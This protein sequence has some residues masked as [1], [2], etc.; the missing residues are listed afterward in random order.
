M[1][2]VLLSRVHSGFRQRRGVVNLVTSSCFLL[3]FFPF[4]SIGCRRQFHSMICSEACFPWFSS[5]LPYCDLFATNITFKFFF[6]RGL[7]FFCSKI[8]LER[9]F[10]HCAWWWQ[11]L[12]QGKHLHFIFSVPDVADSQYMKCRQEGF[13][14]PPDQSIHV[15]VQIRSAE[16]L[17]HSFNRSHSFRWFATSLLWAKIECN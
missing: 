7:L 17:L 16:H 15:F 10:L 2:N 5:N 4:D 12:L 3:V 11:D 8:V 13:L 6:W 9:S 1:K 14:V